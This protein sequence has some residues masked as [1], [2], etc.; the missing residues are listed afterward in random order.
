[1]SWKNLITIYESTTPTITPLIVMKTVCSFCNAVI[2]PGTSPD[3]P[4]SHGVCR[5]CY[6]QI[7]ARHRFNA[8]KYLDMFDA[9]VFLVDDNANVLAANTLARALGKIPASQLKNRLCGTVLECVNASLSP[10]CGKT[11][12]CPDCTIRNSVITTY[13]TGT[14]V[15]DTPAVI[16]RLAEGK[17]EEIPV[18]VS[19]RKDGDAVL[20]RLEPVKTP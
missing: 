8:R 4:V 14:P 6:E 19:T 2:R 11:E 20:L 9:P 7:L 17:V 13:T 16:S 12:A 1:V 15:N 5:S 10:G 18:L 3:D